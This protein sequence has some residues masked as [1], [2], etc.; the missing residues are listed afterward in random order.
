MASPRRALH[1]AARYPPGERTIER[2]FD[3]IIACA[4]VVLCTLLLAAWLGRRISRPVRVLAEESRHVRN[5]DFDDTRP[6][7]GCYIREVND[8]AAAFNQMVEGLRERQLIRDLFGRYVAKTIVN[9]L[10][11][12][13]E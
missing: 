6:V 1:V 8:A 10:L 2:L 9:E 11:R 3:A 13:I 4:I 7:P 12:D 5:L